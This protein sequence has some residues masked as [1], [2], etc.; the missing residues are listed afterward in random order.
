[1]IK[2][3]LNKSCA[4]TAIIMKNIV[5][6][7]LQLYLSVFICGRL[8]PSIPEDD[9]QIYSDETSVTDEKSRHSIFP[10]IL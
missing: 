7:E 6:C 3:F 9:S 5:Y 8:S 2:R 10:L 4:M 1:M